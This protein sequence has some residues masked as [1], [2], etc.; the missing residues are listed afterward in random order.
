MVAPVLLALSAGTLVAADADDATSVSVS[1]Q[2]RKGKGYKFLSKSSGYGYIARWNPC[3]KIHY[4]VNVRKSPRKGALKDTKKAVRRLHRASGLRFKFQGRTKMVPNDRSG[5]P[6]K[7]KT[8]LVIAWSTPK[9]RKSLKRLGGWGGGYWRK[10]RGA[11]Y[12]KFYKGYV[13]L[14]G[15]YRYKY[16][17]GFGKGPKGGAGTRGQLL[18]HELGHAM[19]LAHVKSR[20]QIMFHYTLR[21]K[22]KWGKGDRRGLRK[23]GRPAGC[24]GFG[25]TAGKIAHTGDPHE[26]E[27]AG[28]PALTGRE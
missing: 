7:G 5:K 1:D 8:D 12:G 14:N 15:K 17:K 3:K 6:Y 23:V 16:P 10:A 2:A 25:R 26:H 19:G 20:K 27:H 18:M 4:K 24:G 13:L 22:A 21:R 9:K 11:K 28:L